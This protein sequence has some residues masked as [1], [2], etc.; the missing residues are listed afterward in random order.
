MGAL[1]Y[2]LYL[3]FLLSWTS[4][5]H[6]SHCRM[7]GLISGLRGIAGSELP[8]AAIIL[9]EACNGRVL[10]ARN[11]GGIGERDSIEK[12]DLGVAGTIGKVVR[13]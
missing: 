1:R 2:K 4:I 13:D 9:P 3:M 11:L 12:V 6:I 10:G 8:S 5:D 7:M